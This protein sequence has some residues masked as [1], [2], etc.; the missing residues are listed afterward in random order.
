MPNLVPVDSWIDD[1]LQFTGDVDSYEVYLTGWVDYDFDVVGRDG[2]DPMLTLYD[3]NRTLQDSND[4]SGGTN[5]SHIDYTATSGGWYTL[6]VS[7]YGGSSG[8]FSL[9]AHLDDS[10]A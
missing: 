3:G 5:N 2:F 9:G 6:E 7:G 1:A 8:P 10:M 4:D